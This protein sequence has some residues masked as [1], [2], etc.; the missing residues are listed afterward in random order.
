M[1]SF[2]EHVTFSSLLGVGYGCLAYFAAGYSPQQGALAGC[3]AGIGGMLPDLDLPTGKPGKEIFGLTAA[4]AP[5]VLVGRVQH[6]LHLPNDAETTMLCVV[7]MYLLIRYGLAELVSRFSVHR[8]MFHS[9]PAMLIT[10]E[11]VYLGYPS[12]LN[13]V[14][15]LMGGGIA[16]GFLSHLVLDEI[17]SIKW[18]GGIPE[19]KKSAGT[20][21]KMVGDNFFPNALAFAIL[22]TCTFLVMDEAGL[23]QRPTGEPTISDT[24]PTPATAA[25]APM[26]QQAMLPEELTNLPKPNLG[27]AGQ[28]MATPDIQFNTDSDIQLGQPKVLASPPALQPA[29]ENRPAPAPTLQDIFSSPTSDAPRSNPVR[30]PVPGGPAPVVPQFPRSTAG[31]S[32]EL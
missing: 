5:L 21:M 6:W 2:R 31:G 24:T 4:I 32:Q 1:A 12:K 29:P 26:L 3:L 10:G 18:N 15:L 23:L 14:K 9:Y 17:W 7:A 8:G 30:S 13:M 27:S 19:L 11:V 22:A 20:A 25:K 16:I 28:Q